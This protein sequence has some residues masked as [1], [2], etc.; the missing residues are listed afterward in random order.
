MLKRFIPI[1]PSLSFLG[2]F[3]LGWTLLAHASTATFA[4]SLFGQAS[5]WL[6][7]HAWFGLVIGL[8]L[9]A[10][11]V[12]WPELEPR[13]CKV[14]KALPRSNGARLRFLETE[15]IPLMCLNYTELGKRVSVIETCWSGME[16]NRPIE[17]KQRSTLSSRQDWLEGEIAHLGEQRSRIAELERRL[18]ELENQIAQK[19]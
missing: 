11:A 16:E 9:L 10:L 17:I 2:W 14:L 5:A 6:D 12:G 19:K 7:R 18:D 3:V 4:V 13:L 15:Q 8:I 1:F